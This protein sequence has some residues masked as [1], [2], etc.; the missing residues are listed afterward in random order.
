MVHSHGTGAPP[1]RPPSPALHSLSLHLPGGHPHQTRYPGRPGSALTV[2]HFLCVCISVIREID[3]ELMGLYTHT[4][5]GKKAPFEIV[6]GHF[7]LPPGSHLV[8]AL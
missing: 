3:S 2:C 1:V 7:A 6:L 4:V 8:P 5:V